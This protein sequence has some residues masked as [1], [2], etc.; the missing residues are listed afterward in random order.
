M[1]DNN[2]NVQATLKMLNDTKAH[3]YRSHSPEQET[4]TWKDHGHLAEDSIMPQFESQIDTPIAS[5][6]TQLWGKIIEGYEP[7]TDIPMKWL[8]DYYWNF[9][10]TRGPVF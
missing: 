7:L 8:T 6:Q 1:S 5:T 3:R 9:G 4:Q 2:I 10:T